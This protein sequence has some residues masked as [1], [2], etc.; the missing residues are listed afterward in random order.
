[1][2]FDESKSLMQTN[3]KNKTVG[4][5]EATE[6]L[7]GPYQ[8]KSKSFSDKM[9]LYFNDFSLMPLMIQES[10]LKCIPQLAKERSRTD[11]N[12]LQQETLDCLS[13]AADSISDGDIT[14]R[15]LHQN[16]NWSLMPTCAVFSVVAPAYYSHGPTVA[17]NSWQNYGFPS[18]L[19]QNSRHGKNSRLLK[20]L[21]AKMKN[22]VS[23]DKSEIRQTYIP[24]F[25]KF[26]T[27]PLIKNGKDGIESVIKFM[28]DYYISREDYDSILDIGIGNLDRDLIQKQIET[29]VKTAFTVAY[30]KG[31]HPIAFASS[32]GFSKV[33]GGAKSRP[34]FEDAVEEDDE[35]ASG[36]ENEEKE[37]KMVKQKVKKVSKAKETKPKESKAKSSKA[38]KAK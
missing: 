16:N 36:S 29:K 28:D 35:E 30:N 9:D 22:R 24:N 2:T 34:D 19:G 33:S 13:R 7:L 26:L 21:S 5:F 18:W 14:D 8:N 23:G 15:T 11:A 4:I 1:M 31:S 27:D 3:E 6:I 38:K 37:D 32:T 25:I 12:K 10:Y 17:S 20:E